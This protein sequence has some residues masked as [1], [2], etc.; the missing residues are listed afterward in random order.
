MLN[1]IP[2]LSIWMV[3]PVELQD[4]GVDSPKAS[5]HALDPCNGRLLHADSRKALGQ[6][7]F[8]H[9]ISQDLGLWDST[10]W[11]SFS[12]DTIRVERGYFPE[13]MAFY[14]TQVGETHCH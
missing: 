6:P 1:M 5:V 3:L 10:T 13:D 14:I 11:D 4:N 9:P 12:E 7:K 8:A 2:A